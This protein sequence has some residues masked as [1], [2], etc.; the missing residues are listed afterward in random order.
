MMVNL[1]LV[2]LSSSHSYLYFL[3]NMMMICAE[4]QSDDMECDSEDID[5]IPDDSD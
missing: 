4:S 2:M 1:H 3:A 5:S